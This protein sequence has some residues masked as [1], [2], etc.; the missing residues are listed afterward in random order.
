MC[1]AS[2]YDEK[3]IIGIDGV[4]ATLRYATTLFLHIC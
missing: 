2:I 4:V 3:E 1:G